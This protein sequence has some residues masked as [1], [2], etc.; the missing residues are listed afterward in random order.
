M[1]TKHKSKAT[2]DKERKDQKRAKLC[3]NEQVQQ[4]LQC[5]G[6]KL[7]GE[8]NPKFG[9]YHQIK[10][11]IGQDMITPTLEN[12]CKYLGFYAN[13][14]VDDIQSYGNLSDKHRTLLEKAAV[15]EAKN[16]L[17]KLLTKIR[18]LLI[19]MGAY[20]YTIP[21][22]C[23]ETVA[24]TGEF[25]RSGSVRVLC[26]LPT[27]RQIAEQH[28]YS[29]EEI[30]KLAPQ[31]AWLIPQLII[32]GKVRN[33]DKLIV[34]LDGWRALLT[35]QQNEQLHTSVKRHDRHVISEQVTQ[36]LLFKD[37]DLSA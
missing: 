22:G 14:G 24:E 36:L 31:L 27:A 28:G 34:A 2:L 6:I 8:W 29:E 9:V 16:E 25:K 1:V 15:N 13:Q 5:Y 19:E 32:Y 18:P 37:E 12:L 26:A 20:L 33:T 3:N 11:P 30:K 7:Y 23:V 21:L 35:P 10:T 4:L 17:N